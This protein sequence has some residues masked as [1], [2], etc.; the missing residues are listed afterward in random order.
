MINAQGVDVESVVQ[1]IPLGTR[2][3]DEKTGKVYY[4]A[5]ANEALTKGATLTPMIALF[6]GDCDASSGAVLNDAAV[7][8]TVDTVG[9]FV[10]IN[11][12]TNGEN[13][14]P[15]RVK[16]FTANQLVLENEWSDDLTTSE[17]YIVYKPFLVEN[18]DAA[19]EIIVGVAPIAVTI[20]YF[21]WMQSGGIADDVK[22]I[23][24]T[25]PI[26]ANEGLVSSSTAGTAKGLTAGGTTADEADKSNMIA[27]FGSALTQTVPA[28][29]NCLP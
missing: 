9:A 10:K 11:A 12:G 20:D 3:F 4:Y 16:S 17:D 24:G 18:T 21:F 19:G 29:I 28:I 25:D 1:K 27:I 2:F 13:D 5:Q 15:N 26:V 23:G 7:T 14:T 8:F 6:D 22:V